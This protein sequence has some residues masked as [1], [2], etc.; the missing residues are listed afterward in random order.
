MGWNQLQPCQP[1]LLLENVEAGSYAYFVHSYY[2][3]PANPADML[4]SVDY[5]MTFTAGICHDNI[6]GVQFHPEKS[7]RTG[8]QLLTNFLEM[9]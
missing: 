4:I 3:I 7:Q 5:G 9:N 6:F 8:L 2:C 1:S